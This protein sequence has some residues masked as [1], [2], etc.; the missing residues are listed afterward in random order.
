MLDI[1]I[2]GGRIYDGGGGPP[3]MADVAV[4][5]D[6]IVD[7]G[8]LSQAEARAEIDARNKVITPGFID[9][10]SH[11]D[12]YLL[13]EPSAPSKIFQGVTTELIGNC[14]CSAGPR[15]DGTRMPSDWQEFSY[16]GHWQ[17]V[18]E[19]R[20]LLE[21]MH[22]AVNVGMLVGHNNLRASV[23]GY[24]DRRADAEDLKQMRRLLAES[25]DAGAIGFSTGLL[26]S[27]GMFA[28]LDEV[29][30]LIA[31]L[32]GRG[33]IYTTHMRSEGAEVLEA[34]EETVSIAEKTGCRLEVSHLKTSGPANWH[35]IDALLER[36]ERARGGGVDMAADRYPYTAA[37]TDLDVIL[38]DWAAAGERS[39]ILARLRDPAQRR[40][41]RGELMRG[42]PDD[43]WGRVMVGGT[44]HADN[45]GF[46]GMHLDKVAAQLEME[47]VDAA[48]H[49]I[50][51]DE[52]HTG[53]IFFGMSADNMRRILEQ[54]YVMI[55]SDG[56]LRAPT[57]PLSHDHP[58]PRNYGAFTRFLKM[59][60]EGQ[61]I[62]LSEA[63]RKMTSLPAAHFRLAGRG[64]I[65]A[66][67]YAD[68][69]VFDLERLAD[70]ATF[71]E[72]H[73]L[74][75]GVDSLIVNGKLVIGDGEMLR[76]RPGRV[77]SL[78]TP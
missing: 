29:E 53:G 34:L 47:P 64:V 56:S 61:T 21:R 43:Y 70:N 24:E 55:G 9:V 5:G 58:H 8:D 14:G 37:C 39:D 76:G 49:L 77:L 41:I 60:I 7:I 12:A 20:T 4:A 54:D 65:A 48:L 52:L 19:Y 25:L 15:L 33:G 17:T 68:I 16:P 46:R 44:F 42:R 36:I 71:A 18:K 51:S 13:I 23:M 66:G 74:S 75:G 35:K 67:S 27:P 50:D 30:T 22:P 72:P 62:E 31:D 63:I 6:R 26:Y 57:G 3:M 11:S 40:R 38:P 59:A 73:K 69:A 28:G 2:N 45:L 10:H 1:L 78:D 32:A